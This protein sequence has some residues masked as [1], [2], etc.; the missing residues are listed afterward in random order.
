MLDL[1]VLV[2]EHSCRFAL[3]YIARVLRGIFYA[4]HMK[5]TKST[6]SDE[7]LKMCHMWCKKKT[8]KAMNCEMI[9]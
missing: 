5:S 1:I 9:F 7:S 8:H 6:K 2:L 3:L 4:K